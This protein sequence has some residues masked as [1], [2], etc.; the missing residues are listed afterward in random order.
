MP[1]G[2]KGGTV[3]HLQVSNSDPLGKEEGKS[4]YDLRP[5]IPLGTRQL[6]TE[7][8]NRLLLQ[9][10]DPHPWVIPGAPG[11]SRSVPDPAG[12]P[13]YNLG[14]HRKSL[15]SKEISV[16]CRRGLHPLCGYQLAYRCPS[17]PLSSRDRSLQNTHS[18]V[19]PVEVDPQDVDR[20]RF[21]E[22]PQSVVGQ[23]RAGGENLNLGRL[24]ET[25][26]GI[27]RLWR[28]LPLTRTGPEGQA[29]SGYLGD[30]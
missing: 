7:L 9:C 18:Q 2:G 23:P 21:F 17:V 27:R 19:T 5:P 30:V 14:A 3:R 13:S 24:E 28:V 4:P 22:I 11:E 25:E 20:P 15:R 10:G 16:H 1:F 8:E 6:P 29:K 26:E 12:R